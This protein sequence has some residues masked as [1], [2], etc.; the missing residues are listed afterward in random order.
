MVTHDLFG[1]AAVADRIGLLDKGRIRQEW[2]AGTSSERF[3][4]QELHSAFADVGT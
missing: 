4:V 3:N 2:R 1:A